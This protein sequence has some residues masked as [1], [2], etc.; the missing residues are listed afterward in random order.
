MELSTM[1]ENTL[2][3]QMSEKCDYYPLGSTYPVVI[4]PPVCGKQANE[5]YVIHY[6]NGKAILAR[7]DEH[8]IKNLNGSLQKV[9]S[10]NKELYDVYRVMES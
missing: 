4:F 9:E 2:T 7:C 8:C 1:N 3:P 5:F 10:I 6:N